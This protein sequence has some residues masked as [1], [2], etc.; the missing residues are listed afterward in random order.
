MENRNQAQTMANTLPRLSSSENNRTGCTQTAT[1]PALWSRL[2]LRYFPACA[3]PASSRRTYLDE[4]MPPARP[5]AR[6]TMTP[7][8]STA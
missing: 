5:H 1:S 3:R 4:A 6:L 2:D 8:T 7:V